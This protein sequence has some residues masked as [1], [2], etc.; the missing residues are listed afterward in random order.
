[1]PTGVD[2]PN[3]W[4]L[5][6]ALLDE[7]QAG[8]DALR[9]NYTWSVLHAASIAARTGR[10]GVSVAEFGVAGGNG[11]VAME[12]AAELASD[13]LGVEVD[14]YGFDT[15]EGLPAPRD[16]R[17]A[18]FLMDGGD[19][20]MDPD[21]LRSRLTRAELVLGDVRET[22][23]G[24]L[25]E[26]RH[27]L[28]FISFDLDYYSS[29]RDALEILRADPQ[30]LMP[31]VLCYFDDTHGYPWGDHNGAR[32]AIVEHNERGGD[33]VLDE[34]HGLRHLLPLSQREERWPEAMYIAHAF[35]HPAYDAPEGTEL[36]RRLDLNVEAKA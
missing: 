36:T 3:H 29:T 7:L 24:F 18:P 31:R 2:L 26:R 35:D 10:E 9:P 1:V 23:P 32:L 25:G 12:R 22:I 30:H 20:P 6:N 21:L 34:I 27:E 16:H 19:F 8:D 33:R 17:D 4:F 5:I 11:L 28:G 15:G 14:V 13:R